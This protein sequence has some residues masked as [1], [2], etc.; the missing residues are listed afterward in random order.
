MSHQLAEDGVVCLQMRVFQRRAIELNLKPYKKADI[1]VR[2]I[3]LIAYICVKSEFF[4]MEFYN[5]CLQE[6]AS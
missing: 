6:R 3:L 1:A 4:L 5:I 2:K